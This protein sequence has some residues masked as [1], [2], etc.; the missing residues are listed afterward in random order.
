MGSSFDT[1]LAI[2]TGNTISNLSLIASND[3]IVPGKEVQSSITFTPVKG[4]TYHI[5]VDGFGGASGIVNLNWSQAGAAAPDLIIW[6]PAASPSVVIRTFGSNDCEVVEGCETVG[7]HWLLT[8]TSETRNIGNGDL[9]IGNPATNSLFNWASCHGHYHFEQ[10]ADYS[11]LNTNGDVVSVG[12]KVGFC[13]EDVRAWSSNANYYIRY[14]CNNQGIQSGWAD[15]YGASLPC[16]YI[17]ITGVNPGTYTLRMVVNPAGL[18][19]ESNTNNNITTVSVSIPP[20]CSVP[21]GND[22]FTNAVVISGPPLS[23]SQFNSCSSKQSGEPNHA[24]NVGGHSVWFN[25]T[26]TSN[27]LAVISTRRSDFDTL[28]AVYTGNTVSTLSLV[29]SNDDIS[30]T[31]KQSVVSFSA[32]AGTVYHIAVDGYNGAVGTVT[33]NLGPPANG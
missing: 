10:F 4:T 15:V 26:P 1:L 24:G 22:S 27:Q 21:V 17:D 32:V 3:D 18:I 5:V 12:H 23:I 14:N 20:D 11:L 25:W 16:Q 6:G 13:L 2:Y 9:A 28:L 30:A 19:K 7:T 29:A 31:I 33:L 8:F